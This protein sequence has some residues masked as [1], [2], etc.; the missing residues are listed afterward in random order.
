MD[1]VQTGI[2]CGAG[3]EFRLKFLRRLYVTCEFLENSD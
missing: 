2:T 1:I 3:L